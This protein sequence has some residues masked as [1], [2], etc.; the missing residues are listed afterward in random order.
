MVT[1]DLTSD[2]R[3]GRAPHGGVLATVRTQ[4][5]SHESNG[6]PA[7]QSTLSILLVTYNHEPFIERALI[8]I[9]EQQLDRPVEVIVADDGST[10]RTRGIIRD[11]FERH[12]IGPVR[13]M[14]WSCNR[15]VTRNYQRA[16]A[17]LQTTYVAILEG[18]DYWT[19]P[20][21]LHRQLEVL[22]RNRHCVG[23]S[24]NYM[25][26]LESSRR[27]A[28]RVKPEQGRISYLDA[29]SLIYDNLI[30]N[31]SNCMY[32]V[33]ELRALPASLFAAKSYDWIINIILAQYGPMAFIHEPMSVYRVHASGTWSRMSVAEK[34]Q[35]QLDQIEVYEKFTSYGLRDEWRRLRIRLEQ[36]LKARLGE[37]GPDKGEWRPAILSDVQV[38]SRRLPSWPRLLRMTHENM[39][40]SLLT[41]L[42]ALSPQWLRARVRQIALGRAQQ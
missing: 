30:G 15:G 37:P 18:D 38:A 23:V 20:R 19:S 9:A 7:D 34:L 39:P 12:S 25:V 42:R 2:V 28:P 21:K 32:R 41:I 24:T 3:F 40:R 27:F 5:L 22:N 36:D 11:F 8:S 35:S 10:D 33:A 13:F 31:F 14:D 6:D 26:K 16:F 1:S 29:P 4:D 17:A